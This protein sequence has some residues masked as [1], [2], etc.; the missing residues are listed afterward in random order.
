MTEIIP[1]VEGLSKETIRDRHWDEIIELSK[2]D[3]PY[4]QEETFNLEQLLKAPL[5]TYKEDIEDICEQADKQSKLEKQLNGDITAYWETA[6][7]EIKF[8]KG[9]ENPSILGGNILDVQEKF[10]NDIM[11]LNQMNATRY[12][13]PFK[14]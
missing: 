8:F 1:L 3:I 4:A 14:Q 12:V 5:L 2:T 11:Q 7:F 9:I 13:K 6:E 10:E